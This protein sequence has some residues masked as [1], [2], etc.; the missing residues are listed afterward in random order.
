MQKPKL[1]F[2]IWKNMSSSAQATWNQIPDTDK[3]MIIN[4]LKNRPNQ[5][6]MNQDQ[7]AFVPNAQAKVNQSEITSDIIDSN[8]NNE[9]EVDID[10]KNFLINSTKSANNGL[11]RSTNQSEVNNL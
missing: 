2:N 3:L 4:G 6:E 10:D 5:G 1:G 9:D 8:L 11:Q 7:K